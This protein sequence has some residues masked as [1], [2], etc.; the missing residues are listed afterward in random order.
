MLEWRLLNG[1]EISGARR[2]SNTAG[3]VATANLIRTMTMVMED[4]TT[5]PSS[6][7]HKRRHMTVS[8]WGTDM[9]LLRL[10]G[11]WL[12]R[13]GFPVGTNVRVDVWPR[14][15]VVEVIERTEFLGCAEPNCARETES[16]EC[17]ADRTRM[18]VHW[19]RTYT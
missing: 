5:A 1:I 8:Y 17:R 18:P 6:A 10:Q 7:A 11:H 2:C 9:L 16:S 13:A 15:L 12:G 3:R 19:L 4:S 14:R